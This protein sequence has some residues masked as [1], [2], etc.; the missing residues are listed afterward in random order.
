VALVLVARTGCMI[1]QRRVD[2]QAVDRSPQTGRGY[3]R[4][5]SVGDKACPAIARHDKAQLAGAPS[6]LCI[7][8][9]FLSHSKLPFCHVRNLPTLAY[10]LA[11]IQTFA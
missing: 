5:L 11:G 6:T 1:A 3:R 4:G 10:V 8:E 7:Y 2:K 9:R